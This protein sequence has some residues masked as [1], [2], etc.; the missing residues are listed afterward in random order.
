MLSILIPI[1][2]YNAYPLVQELHKQCLGAKINF[3]IICIDDASLYF[4]SGNSAI[5]LLTDCSLIELQQNNGRSKIRNLL[6]SKSRHDWLL[7]LDCDT[8]PENSDY[9]SKYVNQIEGSTKEAFYGGIKY[10]QDNPAQ[11][12]LL[13][14]IYGNKREAITLPQREKK[15]YKT[16]LVSNFLIKKTVFESVLFDEKISNYGYEDVYFIHSLKNQNIDILHIENPLFHL[17]L[18]TSAQFLSKTEIALET[19][20]AISL[21]NPEIQSHSKVLKTYKTLCFLKLD[22]VVSK[23][24]QILKSRFEENLTSNKPSLLVFDI[25]KIGYFCYLNSK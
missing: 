10:S 2:N 7:F 15:P 12:Q 21:A 16:A 8:F 17:N 23:L 25:Y 9:I 18:E 19:L 1:Y 11:D 3:E 20:L 24:F 5:P 6:A 4:N 13:R 22:I 14:W